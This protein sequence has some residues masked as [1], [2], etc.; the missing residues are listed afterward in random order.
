MS[1][2]TFYATPFNNNIYIT[3]F[4]IYENDNSIYNNIII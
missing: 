2:Y 3:Y 1:R 4:M